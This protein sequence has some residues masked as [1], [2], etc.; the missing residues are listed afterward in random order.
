MERPIVR[1]KAA[2][3]A[4]PS[5]ARR[6]PPS[7][8]PLSVARSGGGT[9]TP[10][11]AFPVLHRSGPTPEEETTAALPARFRVGGTERPPASSR[12]QRSAVS[13]ANPTAIRSSVERGVPLLAQSAGGTHRPG[14]STA[15]LAALLPS[16]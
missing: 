3:S 10:V 15:K 13:S 2:G 1:R 14:L 16:Q 6:E 7:N 8:A 11:R 5:Q 9:G 4:D 12:L